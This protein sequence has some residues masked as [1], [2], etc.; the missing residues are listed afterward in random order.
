MVFVVM[1]LF[2]ESNVMCKLSLDLA[3][4]CGHSQSFTHALSVTI[5]L[6]QLC[7]LDYF[8]CL[9]DQ[10]P[11]LETIDLPRAGHYLSSTIS[12]PKT[13]IQCMFI[14]LSCLSKVDEYK[15]GLLNFIFIQDLTCLRRT[16][17]S[18]KS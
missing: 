4:K 5:S 2:S 9:C 12:S 17:F 3:L 15:I 7:C 8:I 14:E 18:S 11:G 10:I 6:I 1:M 16:I 13:I